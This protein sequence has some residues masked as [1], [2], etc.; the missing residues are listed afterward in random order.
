MIA[1]DR[2]CARVA[3][4]G[5]YQPRTRPLNPSPKGRAFGGEEPRQWARARGRAL[6]FGRTRAGRSS[7]SP[8]K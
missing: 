2:A 4:P 8:R 1:L 5:L 7:L 6:L 3:L